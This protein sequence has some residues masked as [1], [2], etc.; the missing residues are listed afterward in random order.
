M[1][2]TQEGWL[3][4][5]QE[6]TIVS[7]SDTKSEEDK[8]KEDSTPEENESLHKHMDAMDEQVNKLAVSAGGGGE[9]ERERE[10]E[11]RSKT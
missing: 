10:R 7:G 5:E 6:E 1:Q 3:K 8:N 2:G 4:T 11:K 9:R